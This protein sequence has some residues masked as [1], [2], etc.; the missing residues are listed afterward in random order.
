M[1]SNHRVQVKMMQK[2]KIHD[3]GLPPLLMQNP[4]LKFILA[5]KKLSVDRLSKLF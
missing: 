4:Y 5:I 3:H 2:M 1:R